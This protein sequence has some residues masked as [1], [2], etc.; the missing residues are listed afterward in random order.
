MQNDKDSDTRHPTS[1][2]VDGVVSLDID[3]GKTHEHEQ[4]QHA[5]E[6]QFVTTAPGQNHHNRRHADMT[7]GEGRCGLLAR[8]VGT[9]HTLIEQTIAVAG[10]RQCLVV[11]GEV[12]ANI[13][14][15]AVG[16]II[17]ACSQIIILWSCNGQE[18]KDDV[19]D[20]ERRQE[21]KLCAVEL[22][23]AAEEIKQCDDGDHREI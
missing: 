16:N 4:W 18:D 7:T 8:F 19:E 12:V 17:D 1:Y 15:D 20:E 9:L 14:E 5:I 11:G 13:G 10:H 3:G 23:V 6:Q 22:L 21:D 2:H